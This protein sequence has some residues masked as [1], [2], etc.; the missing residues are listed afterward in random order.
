N[1]LILCWAA[2]CIY[3]CLNSSWHAFD[4]S[5]NFILRDRPPSFFH[6]SFK[7]VK[8]FRG[9]FFFIFKASLN[10]IPQIFY[11]VKVRTLAGQESVRRD[12]SSR[13]S[14]AILLRCGSARRMVETEIS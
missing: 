2:I 14:M 6:K 12:F 8:I 5:F 4:K 13:N 9:G 11:W 7:L 10:L 1:S 3:Y